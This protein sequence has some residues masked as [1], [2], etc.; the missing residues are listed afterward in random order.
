MVVTVPAKVDGTSGNA[1]DEG[2]DGEDSGEG[3]HYDMI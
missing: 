3:E 1:S 2:E